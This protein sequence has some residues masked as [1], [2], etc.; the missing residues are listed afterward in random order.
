[1]IRDLPAGQK[2]LLKELFLGNLKILD[3]DGLVAADVL[4]LTPPRTLLGP[5]D[6][7]VLE[8][9]NSVDVRMRQFGINPGNGSGRD[10]VRVR[11]ARFE[12]DGGSI[13]GARGPTGASGGAGLRCEVGSVVHVSFSQVRGGQVGTGGLTA[14]TAIVVAPGATVAVNGTIE[15]RIIGGWGGACGQPG[16]AFLVEQGGALRV[17]HMVRVEGGTS[18]CIATAPRFAGPGAVTIANP[19][20]LAMVF[21]GA[22]AGVGVPA[23]LAVLGMPQAQTVLLVALDPLVQPLPPFQGNPLLVTPVIAAPLG[24]IPPTGQLFASL[25][26]PPGAP[27]GLGVLLQVASLRSGGEFFLSN[28]TVLVSR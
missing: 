13:D 28:S 21:E 19:A 5:G 9:L 10:G 25:R 11:Q 8:I 1:M 6:T 27:P 23:R 20:D 3:C 15:N 18:S 12:V 16:P 24:T 22:I 7:C 17:S 2:V 14:G 26:I 4:L